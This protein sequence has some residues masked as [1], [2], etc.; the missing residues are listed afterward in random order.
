MDDNQVG[1]MTKKKK[2]KRVPETDPT[3]AINDNKPAQQQESAFTA[4]VSFAQRM[5]SSKAI[6]VVSRGAVPVRSTPTQVSTTLPSTTKSKPVKAVPSRSSAQKSPLD[7]L[8][9]YLL[10]DILREQRRRK[11][12]L[13]VATTTTTVTTKQ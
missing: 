13:D 12:Q 8:P 4:S 1:G 6:R 10:K 5:Y 11:Q 3:L 2:K 9:A 7:A